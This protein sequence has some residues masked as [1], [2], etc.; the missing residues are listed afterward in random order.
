MLAIQPW[1]IVLL[2]AVLMLLGGGIGAALW[3]VGRNR[4]ES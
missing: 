1:H 3:A 4:S 2:L